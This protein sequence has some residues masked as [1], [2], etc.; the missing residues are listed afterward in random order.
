MSP[1][2]AGREEEAG[3]AELPSEMVCE[4]MQWLG[5]TD[6]ARSQ[7]VCRHWH[8]LLCPRQPCG[9]SR[10]VWRRA[11][12]NT[13][14]RPCLDHFG[15]DEDELEIGEAR[16]DRNI[17]RPK[18]AFLF[19]SAKERVKVKEENPELGFG[20]I[21]KRVSAKWKEMTDDEKEPFF[22]LARKDKERYEAEL[23]SWAMKHQRTSKEE[24]RQRKRRL[25][26]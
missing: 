20:D 16:R 10:A 4:V 15:L 26:A 22:E 25:P 14:P 2:P 12:F 17:K 7:L 13:W 8:G 19:F 21:T 23:A 6:L 11:Y 9:A 1:P 5:V 24:K 3:V 18:N